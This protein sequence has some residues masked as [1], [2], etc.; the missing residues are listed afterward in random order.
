MQEMNPRPKGEGAPPS[1]FRV[2][3]TREALFSGSGLLGREDQPAVPDHEL[4]RRIGRGAYG[5]VWLAR[6]AL[7]AYRAVKVVHRNDFEDS[8]PFEREFAGIQKFEPISRSHP[9]LVHILQAGRRENYFYY[10]MELADDAGTAGDGESTVPGKEK[11][12]PDGAGDAESGR[13]TSEQGKAEADAHSRSPTRTLDPLT[14]APRTLRRELREQGRLPAD[15]CIEIGLSLGSALGHLHQHGLVHR[16][17]KPSNIIFVQG[18]P[19]LADIGLVTEVGDS[20]SIV[21]TEGYLPPEGPGTPQAD[22]FALGKVLYEAATGLDRRAFP[23]LPPD[24][25]SWPDAK[26]VF[27][28]NEAL[29]KACAKDSAK[30][31]PSAESMLGEL[32]RLRGGKSIRR[33][34]QV[35]RGW[36]LARRGA[37]WVTAI[38][39]VLALA[40]LASRARQPPIA[41]HLGKRSN[42]EAANVLYDL[43]K[44]HFQVFDGTNM[45]VASDLFQRAIQADTNFAA[46][47]GYLACTYAW[48]GFGDWNP[49]WEFFPKAK[50]IALKALALD[51]NLAEPYVALGQYH[52]MWEWDWS[53]AEKELKRAILLNPT[54]AFCHLCYGEF[55]KIVGRMPEALAEMNKALALDAHS[56][57]INGR[58]VYLLREARQFTNALDQIERV[59]AMEPD[60]EVAV[61]KQ[62]IFCALGRFDDA[63][64]AERVSRTHWGASPQA[65]EREL[66]GLKH[67][68]EAEGP[69]AYWRRELEKAKKANDIYWQACCYAQYRDSEAALACLEKAVKDRNVWLTFM[70][71]TEWRLDPVRDTLRFHAILKRMRLE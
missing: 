21:G 9:G 46:A 3:D 31:Y 66:G 19:K 48:G 50:E 61:H 22:I 24:I 49:N 45:A 56:R 71:K 70:V 12:Q 65:L 40:V 60:L 43:G 44:E 34:R 25:R 54:S 11:Q 32:Q 53:N 52:A 15:R 38:T 39:A 4:L 63:I 28:L 59:H 36:R 35:E 41:P 47:Y 37:A 18:K 42:I 13:R 58:L 68:I 64:E 67:A 55:L 10:V 51:T 23:D 62:T 2:G 57:I 27:E 1:V 6:S 8:R 14:Y 5:E 29:I 16:D 69:K 7:G 17:V 20:R 30:R 33:A 26:Q